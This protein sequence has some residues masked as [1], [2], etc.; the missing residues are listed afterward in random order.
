MTDDMRFAKTA[1]LLEADVNGEIVA[2]HIEKG[3]CYGLNEVA[4]R[5]WALLDQPLSVNEICTRLIEEF[6]VSDEEC[7]AEVRK[8]VEQFRSEGL[9]E[10]AA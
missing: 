9:I 2:L 3:Q 6:E 5:V 8:L 4:S 7:K 1:G 10:A